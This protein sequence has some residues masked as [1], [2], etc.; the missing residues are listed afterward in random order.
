MI[1]VEKLRG[2]DL[3]LG[4]M[5][6]RKSGYTPVLVE[7]SLY[8]S[9]ILRSGLDLNDGWHKSDE[10]SHFLQNEISRRLLRIEQIP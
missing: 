2:T 4:Q 10:S 1:F 6:A 5:G 7:T 3:C 9:S 8:R